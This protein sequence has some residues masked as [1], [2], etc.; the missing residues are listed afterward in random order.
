[1]AHHLRLLAPATD[2]AVTAAGMRLVFAST[3]ADAF[4]RWRSVEFGRLPSLLRSLVHSWQ[5]P[6]SEGLS[7]EQLT[8][9]AAVMDR[10]RG[11]AVF[12]HSP[13]L[14]QAADVPIDTLLDRKTLGLNDSSADGQTVERRWQAGGL[15][16]GVCLRNAGRLLELLLAAACP[17]ATFSGHLHRATRIDVDRQ[18]RRLR[19]IA[20]G[21]PVDAGRN[22]VLLT[23]AAVGQRHRDPSVSP[24][25]L[26]AD[27]ADG[28]LVRLAECRLDAPE[29]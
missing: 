12:F 22:A 28:Q 14:H 9:I 1:L 20:L 5:V 24:G 7:D 17:V 10:A 15:R 21:S 25:Y 6:D 19:S 8:Q 3:G 13:L 4:V 16:N 27:F 23:A 11:A 26:K 29:M 18:A 2:F